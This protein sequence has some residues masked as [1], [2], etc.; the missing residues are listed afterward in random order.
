MVGISEQMLFHDRNYKQTLWMVVSCQCKIK[1][2][3]KYL[4]K[5]AMYVH[6]FSEIQ[7]VVIS[8]NDY[9]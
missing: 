2:I 1:S 9:D 4:S 8:F 7:N 5:K 3:Q 6:I